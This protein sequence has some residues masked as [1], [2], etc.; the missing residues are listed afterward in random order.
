MCALCS[1]T[2]ALLS[3]SVG[4]LPVDKMVRREE[5]QMAASGEILHVDS[6]SNQM[7]KKRLKDYCNWDFP[8]GEEHSD[9]CP[10]GSEK[11]QDKEDCE[12]AAVQAGLQYITVAV[13]DEVNKWLKPNVTAGRPVCKRD[14]V[15]YGWMNG[16]TEVCPD[17]YEVVKNEDLCL[18]DG[19]CLGD[20][21][22]SQ[23]LV[24]KH[25][26]N[27]YDQHPLYCFLNSSNPNGAT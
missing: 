11:L 15:K 20:S 19:K 6:K 5:V 24:N 14:R 9:V 10:P 12:E 7:A 18:I 21:D 26:A 27:K 2:I 4:A 1:A 17:S 22:A 8:L 13:M 25:D 16:T 23:S 3:L